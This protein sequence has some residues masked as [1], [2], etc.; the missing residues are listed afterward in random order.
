MKYTKWD[1]MVKKMIIL[2]GNRNLFPELKI[3]KTTIDYWLKHSKEPVTSEV[4]H[5]YEQVIKVQK[6]EIFELKAKCAVVSR[7]LEKLVGELGAYDK[8]IKEN[9]KFVIETIDSYRELL[10]LKEIINIVGI[11]QTTY[12]RWRVEVYGCRYHELQKK[13]SVSAP[14]QL[15]MEE[16]KRLVQIATSSSFH[17]FSTVSLMHYCK[18]KGILHLS[19]ESWYKYLKLYGIERKLFR[20]KKK[21]I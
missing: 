3:P 19:L 9:R 10:P 7:C 18:R 11:S 14:N 4:D 5:A 15:T 12:Y 21:A 8:R 16:Q 1:P 17:K 2:T 20:H 13:C 6:K